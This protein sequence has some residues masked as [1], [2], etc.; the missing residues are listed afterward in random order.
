MRHHVGSLETRQEGEL[1][2]KYALKL[3]RARAP[4]H[5]GNA[6]TPISEM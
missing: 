2:R 3:N 6:L 5:V 4:L 1:V